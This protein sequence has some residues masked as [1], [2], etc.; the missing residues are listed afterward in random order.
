[1]RGRSPRGE[2]ARTD[3]A[4]RA[5]RHGRPALA[6]RPPVARTRP[7]LTGFHG[8]V[9][10]EAMLRMTG[11]ETGR[12][13]IA[14]LMRKGASIGSADRRRIAL[15]G[16]RWCWAALGSQGFALRFRMAPRWG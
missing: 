15:S 4:R 13:R 10:P 8:T 9:E 14:A 16:L 1:M 7:F 5:G 3:H 11:V 6:D 2:T 12:E